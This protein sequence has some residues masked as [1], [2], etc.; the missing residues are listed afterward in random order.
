MLLAGCC[1]RNRGV[2]GILLSLVGAGGRRTVGLRL[3]LCLWLGDAQLKVHHLLSPPASL[4][5]SCSCC[6]AR[7]SCLVVDA[8]Q[9]TGA[10]QG[11]ATGQGSSDGHR[12]V[13]TV[14]GECS[15]D[16]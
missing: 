16:L 12:D 1:D 8:P 3:G 5:P 11:G 7:T 6:C 13:L 9:E 15:R 14:G 10:L 4:L 2:S